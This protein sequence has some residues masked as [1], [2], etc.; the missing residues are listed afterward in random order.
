MEKSP[1]KYLYSFM[2]IIFATLFTVASCSSDNEDDL[3]NECQTDNV[4]YSTDIAPIM[5]SHCN[6]CHS[7]NAATGGINTAS[8][9]G[10]K[11]IAENGRLVGSVNHLQGFRPMPEGQPQLPECPRL[12]IASWVADGAENN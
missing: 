9:A 11:I 2:I 8:F 1:V 3:L 6:G 5:A 10:L 7:G 12:Q 4:S